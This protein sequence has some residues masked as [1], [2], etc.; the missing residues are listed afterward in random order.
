MYQVYTSKL[1]HK[2]IDSK[3]REKV[4]KGLMRKIQRE[5]NPGKPILSKMNYRDK[6]YIEPKVVVKPKEWSKA[7]LE[8]L[9]GEI[10]PRVSKAKIDSSKFHP[11]PLWTLVYIK[12]RGSI[13]TIV[14]IKEKV[15]MTRNDYLSRKPFGNAYYQI[16][17]LNSKSRAKIKQKFTKDPNNFSRY[18][19]LID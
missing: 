3:V 1:E 12:N 11:L 9:K 14:V 15:R 10:I 18:E 13:L 17:A 4:R 2:I 7:R 6:N 8:E 19:V 5:F 16:L